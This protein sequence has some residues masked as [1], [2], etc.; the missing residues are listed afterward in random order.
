MI[1]EYEHP[2]LAGYEPI[3]E[4]APKRRRTV[5]IMRT[6]VIVGVL[7]LVLPE[8][9]TIV[10]VGAENAQRSCRAWVKYESPSATGASARFELF[11]SQGIGYECYATGDGGDRHVASLGLIP[12]P[13]RIPAGTRS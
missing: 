13:P 5:I 2:E 7:A 10:T 11:G 9:F 1:D 6:V 4:P 3:G 8:L 12:G